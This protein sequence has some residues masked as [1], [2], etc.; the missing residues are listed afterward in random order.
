LQ[1]DVDRIAFRLRWTRWNGRKT[2]QMVIEET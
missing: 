2:A 1:E